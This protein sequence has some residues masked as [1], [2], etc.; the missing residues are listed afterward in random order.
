MLEH[1]HVL[2]N[3]SVSSDSW[4]GE[5]GIE[6]FPGV[7]L[8]SWCNTALVLKGTGNVEDVG[9]V[10]NIEGLWEEVDLP[11][12]L[13]LGLIKVDTWWLGF[14]LLKSGSWGGTYEGNKGVEFHGY[15][16]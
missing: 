6:E 7:D 16:K 10:S 4:E 12:E 9:P 2:L 5:G 11:I 1:V 15:L 13:S 8:E 14:G 3:V